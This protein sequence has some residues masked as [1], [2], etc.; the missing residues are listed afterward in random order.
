M[1]TLRGEPVDR[2]AVSFYEI[3]GS[4]D[5]EDPDPFN[6]YNHPSWKPLIELA[7]N[8]TD[9]IVMI[10]EGVSLTNKSPDPLLELTKKETHLDGDGSRL[11]STTI[12][13]GRRILTART[14]RDRDINT[15]W[16]IEHLLKDRDD[17]R[18]YLELPELLPGW[19]PDPSAILNVEKNLGDSGIVMVDHSDPLCWAAPLFEMG[20][21]TV[22]AMTEPDLFRRLLDRFARWLLPRTEVIARALPGR[23]WR[24]CGP[25]YASPPYLPPHF[26][27]EYVTR[28]DKPMVEA[29]QRYGGFARLH[30]HGRLKAILDDIAQ[31]GC[32]GLDPIEPPPQGD[33]ELQYV[34][35]KYGAQFVLF[36]NL[37]ASDLENLETEEFGGKIERALREGTSGRGFVLMP[38]SC[39]YGRVLSKRALSNYEKMVTMAE[40]LLR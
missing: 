16:T 6:I 20:L 32:V 7:R 10:W 28:Y 22:T 5:T 34:R 35:E 12:K 1:A 30:C 33:V 27:H 38:S 14:K 29:I 36:G 21:F 31:T 9:R 4:Q 13:A 25:E 40:G 39:P 2:P 19:E 3:D 37:E 18:A 26:F 24:I 23:L 11:V 15:V 8:R 17:L